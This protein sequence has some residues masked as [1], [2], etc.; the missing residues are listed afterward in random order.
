MIVVTRNKPE[1]GKLNRFTKPDSWLAKIC[2]DAAGGGYTEAQTRKAM[3]ILADVN[4]RGR[5]NTG[6]ITITKEP[7]L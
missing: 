6:R 1:P 7:E 2:V 3:L 4:E 5:H